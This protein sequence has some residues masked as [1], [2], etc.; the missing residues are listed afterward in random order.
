MQSAASSV[1]SPHAEQVL[2]VP[3]GAAE[4]VTCSSHAV[5]VFS[6]ASPVRLSKPAEHWHW[7]FVVAVH[8]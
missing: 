2:H 7:R 1:P 6:C 5:H 3:P 4:N 8:S